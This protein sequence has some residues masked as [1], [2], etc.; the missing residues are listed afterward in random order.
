MNGKKY[1]L[2]LYSA[3]IQEKVESFYLKCAMLRLLNFFKNAAVLFFC[4]KNFLPKLENILTVN[5]YI[6]NVGSL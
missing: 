4:V 3:N 2:F 5:C 6:I 1:G